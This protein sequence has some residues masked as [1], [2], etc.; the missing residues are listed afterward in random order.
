MAEISKA[1]L[2]KEIQL[3]L[4]DADL[5]NTSAKKVRLQLQ[6]KLDVDLTERKKE[7]DQLVM[8]V[9]DEQTQDD[10]EEEEEEEDEEEEEEDEAPPPKKK[11]AP[12]AKKRAASVSG[13]E[14]GEE[15]ASGSEA[16]VPS[17]GGGS[18]YEPDEP[19][20]ISKGRKS[21][22]VSKKG[23]FGSD[24]ESSGEEWG[25]AKKGG[26]KKGRKKKSQDSDDSDYEKP[27]KK[28]K[29]TPGGKPNGYTAAVKLSAELADIVGG[30][31]MPRHEVVKRMWAYIKENNLQDP[32]NKQMIKCDEKLSKVIPTKKFRGFG[33]TKFLKDHMNVDKE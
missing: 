20:K 10:G 8:E 24:E 15:D 27:K 5:D 6:E 16:E 32:K 28:R 14:G 26:S 21:A 3:I 33:M 23:K 18:D 19:V 13:S 2:K 29:S 1:D 25:G 4:K 12:K 30:E 7:V 22:V 11:A 9:I 31:E 17:D